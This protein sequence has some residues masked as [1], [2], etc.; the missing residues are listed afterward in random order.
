MPGKMELT[1]A[2]NKPNL[3]N[4]SGVYS[5]VITGAASSEINWAARLPVNKINM[6]L[7]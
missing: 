3:P 2:T 5:L 1:I 4:A 7:K 6:L